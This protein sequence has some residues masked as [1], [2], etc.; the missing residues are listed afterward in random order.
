MILLVIALL[1]G[2]AL[3]ATGCPAD[4]EETTTTAPPVETTTTGAGAAEGSAVYSANCA[5]CH[6]AD[7]SGGVGPDL[8]GME[9]EDREE[10]IQVVTEGRDEMPAFGGQLSDAEIEAVTDYV[11]T[12]Q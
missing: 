7:G 3:L 5:G 2:T 10:L 9:A 11:L 1:V 6:G 8:R 4:E 12:L